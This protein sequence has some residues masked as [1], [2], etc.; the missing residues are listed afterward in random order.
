MARVVGAPRGSRIWWCIK[1]TVA[2][3]AS[4]WVHA[5]GD[6][7]MSKGRIWPSPQFFMAQPF[8]LMLEAAVIQ[9]ADTYKFRQRFPI[10]ST[11]TGVI[12]VFAWFSLTYPNFVHEMWVIDH[13]SY[14]GRMVLLE[15]YNLVSAAK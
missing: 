10:I 7:A 6:Y 11:M 13:V 1:V 9:V 3:T 15:R 14:F 8:A 4:T 2:F 5:A 12:W